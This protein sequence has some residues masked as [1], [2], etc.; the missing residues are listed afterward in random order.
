MELE[1]EIFIVPLIL[2]VFFRLHVLSYGLAP[3]LVPLTCTA[4]QT[5]LPGPVGS[6]LMLDPDILSLFVQTDLV[7]VVKNRLFD[8]KV[9]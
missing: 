7:V 4:A 3:F 9:N 5:R 6:R 2:D 1:G 8:S